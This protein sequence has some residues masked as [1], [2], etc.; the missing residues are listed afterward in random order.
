MDPNEEDDGGGIPE[1]VVTFGD[2]MSLLLT[3]FIMLVSLSEMKEE[4]KF[5]AMVD[6][7][8][9]QFG[10]ESAQLAI[11]PG[12]MQPRNS[13]LAHLA[14]MGRA[15]KFDTHRGGDKVKA[16]V[17]DHPRVRIIRPGSKTTIGTVV[18]FDEHSAEMLEAQQTELVGH[19]EH[20]G[21]KPQK[22]EVRGHTSLRPLDDASA[23]QSQW[24]LAFRRCQAVQQV[25]V[26][27]GI[28]PA[29][30]RLSV[31][32]PNEPLHAGTDPLLLKQNPR[33]EVFLLDEYVDDLRGDP[34]EGDTRFSDAPAKSAI[35]DF[36]TPEH[37][38][39]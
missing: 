27:Q 9:Q 11:V 38:R 5:Q 23:Y 34:G 12:N 31:A 2:M 4:E 19:V 6:S 26:E 37:L 36:R 18:A 24:E 13:A 17:G 21:G 39:R 29:R 15:S 3:F 1:W 32:G 20:F 8:R 25:L 30:L 35:L 7:I 33:V 14:T 10:H 16:P 22:I 28:E